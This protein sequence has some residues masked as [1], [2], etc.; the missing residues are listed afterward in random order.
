[1][2]DLQSKVRKEIAHFLLHDLQLQQCCVLS[3][4][5]SNWIIPSSE[6]KRR[7][8]E[9]V[10]KLDNV[11]GQAEPDRMNIDIYIVQW[12]GS[13]PANSA[14]F[15]LT[16]HLS[17]FHNISLCYKH[18]YIY[19]YVYM[20][21]CVYV[22]MRAY[23]YIFLYSFPLYIY[24]IAVISS[25]VQFSNRKIGTMQQTT[26]NNVIYVDKHIRLRTSMHMYGKC[27]NAMLSI[28]Q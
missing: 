5:H 6:R 16:P 2:T 24:R 10:A 8:G 15:H 14:K 12:R 13:F 19:I 3:L 21:V 20:R 28:Y 11:L 17:L 27:Q 25:E 22:C 23:I 18:I 26:Q 1:M 9:W 4:Q 7:R